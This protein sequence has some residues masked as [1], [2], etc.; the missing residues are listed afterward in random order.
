MFTERKNSAF[1]QQIC[2]DKHLYELT[3]NTILESSLV[4]ML[5]K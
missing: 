1:M 3:K 4:E 5:S 2:L